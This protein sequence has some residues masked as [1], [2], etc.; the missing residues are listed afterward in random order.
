MF[1]LYANKNQLTVRKRESVTSG[2]VNAYTAR[3]EFSPDWQG[4]TAKAVFKGSGTTKTV[5][6][7]GGECVIPWEVL[8]SHGQPLMAGV[9]G[10][11]DD[12]VL[13]TIWASLGAVLEGV[14]TDGEG[15]KPPT[16]DLWEQELAA[17]QDKLKGKPGQV[18]GFDENGN[19]IAQ[20]NTGGGAGTQGPPGPQGPE[21]PP[22]PA[23]PKGDTGDPGP[24]GPPGPQGEKGPAGPTG[25]DGK[26][27]SP[28]PQGQQ[29]E[30]GLPGKD[31][32]DGTTF[33]PSVSE[34]GTL[35]WTNDG[36]LPNPEPVNIKG[37]PGEGTQPENVYSTEEAKVGTWIDGKPLYRKV[38]IGL[39]PTGTNTWSTLFTIENAEI[40]GGNML[41]KQGRTG[42][43]YPAPMVLSPSGVVQYRLNG[44]SVD[45]YNTSGSYVS[46]EYRF[47]AEY[48]KTTDQATASAEEIFPAYLGGFPG[49]GSEA[50]TLDTVPPDA[51]IKGQEE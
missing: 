2:S 39:A 44:S 38:I 40:V 32:A 37:P 25:A 29:G 46:S 11:L 22:G 5:L 31:G 30:R 1:I 18:V 4:L 20:D 7:D 42:P 9:F 19:A 26:D 8:T 14:P 41:I 45:M 16:P 17:K 50:V 48:T 27:G 12:T 36:G 13:P 49:N 35:S 21:G 6:L 23:G 34:D 47:C 33:T 15:A 28:G 51:G 10:T 43:Q 24:Q 3:F